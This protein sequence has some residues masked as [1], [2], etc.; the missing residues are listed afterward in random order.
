MFPTKWEYLFTENRGGGF[1]STPKE[2]KPDTDRRL[3]RPADLHSNKKPQSIEEKSIGDQDEKQYLKKK[4]EDKL[5]DEQ[6][7][8][9]LDC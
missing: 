4:E 9:I 2:K 1:S 8:H 6:T 5:V 7:K 3:P